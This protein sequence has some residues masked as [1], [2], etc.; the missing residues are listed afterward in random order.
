MAD[1]EETVREVV[2]TF[3]SDK[4]LQSAIDA[5]G[6]EHFSRQEVSVIGSQI[7]LKKQF[8]TTTVAP[9]KLSDNPDTPRGTNITPEEKGVGTGVAISSGIIAGVVGALCFIEEIEVFSA[10]VPAAFIGGIIG[11]LCGYLLARLIGGFFAARLQKQISRG[12][13]LLWVRVSN[14]E[15]E[16]IA[17][18]ILKQHG[19]KKVHIHQIE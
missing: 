5:L 11:A 6:L 9:K 16:L 4:E 12:G 3:N 14:Q 18:K 2:G 19:G 10:S 13:L 7:A 1:L 15:Q 8:N 17:C